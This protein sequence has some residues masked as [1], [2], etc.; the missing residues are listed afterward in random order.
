M[1]KTIFTMLT[2]AFIV[3]STANAQVGVGTSTPD[4]SAALEV[5]STTKGFLPPRMTEADR[6]NINNPATGLIIYCTNCGSDGELQVYNGTVW[7]NS[8]G[9]SAAAA[10]L[11]VGDMHQGG[12][13]AYILQPG[14]PGYDPNEQHGLIVTVADVSTGMQWG[15]YGV[16]TGANG[17]ALG[18]GNQNTVNIMT[19]CSTTNIAAR[20]CGDLIEGGYSDWYLPS[21]VEIQK[22]R[23]NRNVIGGFNETYYWSSTENNNNQARR[24][25]FSSG[26]MNDQSKNS[27][28]KFRA[29]RSF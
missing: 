9:D 27:P 20:I 24:I 10:P 6:Q 28:Y 19:S 25:R 17:T 2:L 18:T 1:K 21:E 13:I 3:F 29:V 14:D 15:C 5:Q 4:A 23:S 12:K 26:A 7:T 16:I 8:V 22:I 11:A